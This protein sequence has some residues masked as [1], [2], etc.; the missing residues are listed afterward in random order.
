[1]KRR[2]HSEIMMKVSRRIVVL[3]D[4]TKFRAPSLHRFCKIDRI[5][6]IV[7]DPNIPEDFAGI[8]VNRG[9]NLLIADL[10]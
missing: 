4:S 10:S 6:T 5:D 3:V 7:T 2:R 1:M 8:L 9:I